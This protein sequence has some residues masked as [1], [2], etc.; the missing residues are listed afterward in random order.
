MTGMALSLRIPRVNPAKNGF[1]IIKASWVLV[2]VKYLYG[3]LGLSGLFWG[4]T[5]IIHVKVLKIHK[6]SC[7]CTV[8]KICL[9]NAGRF[10]QSPCLMSQKNYGLCF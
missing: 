3:C 10:T 1:E 5:E 2:L 8:T 4:V 7:Q 9:G 6:V